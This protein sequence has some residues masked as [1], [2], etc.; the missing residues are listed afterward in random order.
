MMR[1]HLIAL[2]ALAGL[3]A[4]AQAA[5]RQTV[6]TG[7]QAT[8]SLAADLAAGTAID[9]AFAF[10]ANMR[11]EQQATWLEQKP[12]PDFVAAA[13]NASAAI[14]LSRAWEGDPLYV[15][16]RGAN[17]RIVPIDASMPYNPK[18]T[19][20]GVLPRDNG[21]GALPWAWHSLSNAMRMADIV[22]ADLK[23]LSPADAALVERN[24]VALKTT[25]QTLKTDYEGRFLDAGLPGLWAL[26]DRFAYLTQDFGLDV[27]GHTLADTYDWAPED[28]ARL[29]AEI[30]A[31]DAKVVVDWRKPKPEMEAAVAATGAKLVVLETMDPPARLAEGAVDARGFLAAMR[32]NLDALDG[33][34]RQK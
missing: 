20:I 24:Q 30:K 19:G 33:A 13:A 29:A 22:A 15:W 1:K 23:A 11:M 26:T 8:Y 2:V 21:K 10:P 28:Y 34:M 9:V 4:P 6:L 18:V 5:E 3:A 25:L 27:V 32:R 14:V 7:L 12:R 31:R 16:S 17:I